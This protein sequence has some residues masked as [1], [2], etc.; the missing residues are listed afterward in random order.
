MWGDNLGVGSQKIIYPFVE[1]VDRSSY[2]ERAMI[3]LSKSVAYQESFTLDWVVGWLDA[4]SNRMWRRDGT[5]CLQAPADNTPAKPAESARAP[6]LKAIHAEEDT[7]DSPERRQYRSITVI[8]RTQPLVLR[9]FTSHPFAMGH[10]AIRFA[11]IAMAMLER[12][13]ASR[14]CHV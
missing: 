14:G 4:V 1:H 8:Q 11:I 5:R 2:C 10:G 6:T 3:N 9:R 12:H 13:V 7:R